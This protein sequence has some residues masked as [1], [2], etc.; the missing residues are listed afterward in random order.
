M[1]DMQVKYPLIESIRLADGRYYL[2]KLHEDRIRKARYHLF[3]NQDDFSLSD[4]FQQW[5]IPT[6]GLFKC[7]IEYGLSFAPPVFI[8][9]QY[10]IPD[11][12]KLVHASQIDYSFKYSDRSII[13]QLKASAADH[14]DIL[15]VI[16]GLITD[17]SYCNIL[18]SHHGSW[19]TPATPLLA[20]VQREYL[21]RRGIIKTAAIDV[22]SLHTFESFKLIN[23]MIPFEQAVELPMKLIIR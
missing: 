18:F 6:K 16:N 13:Q 2:L 8:P 9:Y 12:I 21:L 5:N 10:Q 15:I 3:D 11:S 19:V 17:S 14:D 7:R 23:A 20:G 4:Y 22:D 1:T